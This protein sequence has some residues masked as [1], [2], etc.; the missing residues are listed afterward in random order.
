MSLRPVNVCACGDHAWSNLTQGFVV[1]VDADK[2]PILSMWNWYAKRDRRTFRPVRMSHPVIDGVSR[3]VTVRLY[4]MLLPCPKGYV[5]DHING[6]ALDNRS[7]NLRPAT[8]K[9]NAINRDYRGGLSKYRGVSRAGKKWRALIT[10]EGKQIMLGRFETEI[11]AALAYD[12]AS[13][14]LHGEFSRPNFPRN[15]VA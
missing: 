5:I 2:A 12:E 13:V 9:Q 3:S 14:R 8:A 1:L 11:D 6:N 4:S 7:Q 10:S 15:R